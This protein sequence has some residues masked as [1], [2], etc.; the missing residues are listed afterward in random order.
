MK[1]EGR[2]M[3]EIIRAKRMCYTFYRN[4]KVVA[5]KLQNFGTYNYQDAS[6]RFQENTSE[7]AFSWSGNNLQIFNVVKID[8]D[9]I[10]LVDKT[11][12]SKLHLIPLDL[13]NAD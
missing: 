1:K 12:G 7:L 11:D 13:P 6:Y 8:A 4:Q 10:I 2:E 5:N 9:D 3:N